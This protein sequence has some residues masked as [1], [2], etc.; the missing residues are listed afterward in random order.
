MV[1]VPV[2]PQGAGKSREKRMAVYRRGYQRYRGHINSRWKR[3]L[4]LPRFAWQRLFQQRLVVLLIVIALVYPLLCATF[5]Y[6][7]N[8]VDLLKG[9]GN[10]FKSFIKVDGNFF[11]VFMNVQA[12]FAVF[13]AAMA[14][15]G[16]IAPDLA[17]NALPLYFSRP[18]TRAEYAL[19]RII[20]L[21]GMLSTITLIP[22]LLLFGMQVGMADEGW[23]LA[24]W[25]MGL[26]IFAGFALWIFLVSL[27]ALASSAYVK[28]RVVAGGLVLGFFFLLSGASVMI[29]GILRST[30]GYILNPAWAVRRL[31][32]AMLSVSPPTGPGIWACTIALAV[33]IL[34]LVLV[35]KRKLRPVEVIS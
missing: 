24:N 19:A 11:M 6:I 20:T 29:N 17:N 27:V 7:S 18:L 33:L 3:F 21:F 25:K 8:H 2:F 4:V 14:G 31:W 16:L 9:L 1:T 34:L 35:L 30:W 23:F 22:G 10:E 13:L 15:P 26:G 32:Y 5:I 12:V 28:L